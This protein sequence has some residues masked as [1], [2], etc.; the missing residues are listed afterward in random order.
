VSKKGETL[1]LPTAWVAPRQVI[2][3][4]KQCPQIAAIF[5]LKRPFLGAKT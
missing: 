3:K 1:E 2:D 5:T 4:K